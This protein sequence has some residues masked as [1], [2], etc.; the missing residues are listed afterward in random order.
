MCGRTSTA[1]PHLPVSSLFSYASLCLRH[2]GFRRQRG[3][4]TDKPNRAV[5]GCQSLCGGV[6][7]FPMQQMSAPLLLPSSSCLRAFFHFSLEIPPVQDLFYF[8]L[9]KARG[10]AQS[11]RAR[12]MGP[13][14]QVPHG[15]TAFCLELPEPCV[16]R[17]GMLLAAV[18]AAAVPA[19]AWWKSTLKPTFQLRR[20]KLLFYS[21][22]SAPE[23]PGLSRKTSDT[24]PCLEVPNLSTREGSFSAVSLLP[25][26]SRLQRC[27]CPFL[28]SSVGC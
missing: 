8:T 15:C 22:H 3:L 7:L 19:K 25:A 11:H 13:R 20:N 6:I 12:L 26:Y 5:C 14:L 23:N 28:W 27:L 1:S 18:A 16:G 10:S 2:W 9:E 4:H 21:D 17:R 24:Q